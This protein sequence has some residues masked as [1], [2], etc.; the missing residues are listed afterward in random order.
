MKKSTS[1]APT[2][3]KGGEVLT[4]IYERVLTM[5][6]LCR[7][8]PGMGNYGS[9][10]EDPYEEL[11][12]KASKFISTGIL[13]VDY[14][15][16][17]WKRQYTLRDGSTL[18]SKRQHTSVPP[19]RTGGGRFPTPSGWIEVQADHKDLTKKL[20]WKMKSVFLHW[21]ESPCLFHDHFQALQIHRRRLYTHE[22]N[23]LVQDQ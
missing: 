15:D 19:S 3:M 2:N 21:V 9:F 17:Y 11:C 5:G 10:L 6:A 4:V 12:V 22:S 8:P 20:P 7:D 23:P 16:K 18:S 14:A 13:E 1:D